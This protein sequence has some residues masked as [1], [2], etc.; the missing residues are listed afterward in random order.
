[1]KITRVAL[2][3]RGIITFSEAGLGTWSPTQL[4]PIQAVKT[5]RNGLPPFSLELLHQRAVHDKT[6][7]VEQCR[8]FN[9]RMQKPDFCVQ[10]GF[11]TGCSRKLRQPG[12]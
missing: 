11:Q 9:Y 4:L 12:R 8:Q 1:M 6:A 3:D 2:T 7:H 10:G 5:A